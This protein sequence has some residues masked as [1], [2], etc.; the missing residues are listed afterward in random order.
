[1][2]CLSRLALALPH[3]VMCITLLPLAMANAYA[4]RVLRVK[5]GDSIVVDSNYTRM[6]L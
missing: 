6:R 1:M 4:E 5:D 2:P 3:W